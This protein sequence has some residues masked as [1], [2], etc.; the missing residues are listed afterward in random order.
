VRGLPDVDLPEALEVGDALQEQHPLDHFLGVLH[1]ADGVLAD[2]AV[3][4]VEAPVFA[5][6]TMDE[7]LVD[8]GQLGG[9]DLVQ[10]VDDSCVA[11][12]MGGA[13][14]RASGVREVRAGRGGCRAG[15]AAGAGIGGR[16]LHGL[17]GRGAG[18]HAA[19]GVV[20]GAALI[21]DAAAL[22]VAHRCG[23][24][25]DRLGDYPVRFAAADAD[26]HVVS[27]SLASETQSQ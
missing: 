10:D 21:A 12:H 5:H 13:Y 7:I 26:D 2:D 25:L 4:P 24:V 16:L 14:H 3:E 1:L 11:L 17:F 9:E 23:A 6:L 22:K 20:A 8:G 27:R 18:Q 15:G 19:E